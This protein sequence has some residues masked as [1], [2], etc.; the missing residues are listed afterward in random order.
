M[1]D[2]IENSIPAASA[3]GVSSSGDGSVVTGDGTTLATQKK[4]PRRPGACLQCRA[5]HKICDGLKPSKCSLCERVGRECTYPDRRAPYVRKIQKSSSSKNDGN[6]NAPASRN[7][8]RSPSDAY[9]PPNRLTATNNLVL[10]PPTPPANDVYPADE[11]LFARQFFQTSQFAGFRSM[12]FTEMHRRE[13]CQIKPSMEGLDNG[14][15]MNGRNTIPKVFAILEMVNVFFEHIHPLLPCLHESNILAS[16]RPGGY[17]TK[18]NALTFA[19]LAISAQVHP[20][21]NFRPRAKK[22]YALAKNHFHESESGGQYTLHNVQAGIYICLYAYLNADYRELWFFI[23]KVYRMACVLGLSHID[24]S[25]QSAFSVLYY[26]PHPKSEQDLEER[27]RAFWGIYVLDRYISLGYDWAMAISDRDIFV[28]FPIRDD[29]FQSG[30]IKR[31]SHIV[32]EPFVYNLSELIPALSNNSAPHPVVQWSAF[33]YLCK[34]LVLVGQIVA[35]RN[36]VTHK[37]S[38]ISPSDSLEYN[39]LATT[40]AQFHL[41]LPSKYRD[42]D[43]VVP[44]ELV[45]V[46]QVNIMLHMATILL[47]HPSSRAS[48]SDA[49]HMEDSSQFIKCISAAQNIVT[50]LNTVI[51]T[52]PSSSTPLENPFLA[53]SLLLAAE[54]LCSRYLGSLRRSALSFRL[55]SNNGTDIDDRDGTPTAELLSQ[56]FSTP[57]SAS[58]RNNGTIPQDVEIILVALNQMK[59]VCP[60]ISGKYR[61][62]ILKLMGLRRDPKTVSQSVKNRSN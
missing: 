7:T 35:H 38:P 21:N 22:W 29:V 46:T 39:E 30:E 49:V 41:I 28:N 44:R 13:L 15:I 27:R 51:N 53:P 24:S 54:V 55:S 57:T 4:W 23:A 25:R 8:D 14:H 60:A 42:F 37:N 48:L 31:M 59:K 33:H 34:L 11:N 20:D 50:L 12:E 47:H 32:V 40:L 56:S 9:T 10:L 6:L 58:V 3:Q 18:P 16:I 43:G 62:S 61:D 45:H 36:Y 17:L 5:L 2:N 19:I 52:S 26:L 1:A